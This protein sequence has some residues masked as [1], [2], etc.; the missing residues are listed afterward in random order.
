MGNPT[1][2][3]FNE[4]LTNYSVFVVLQLR[5][6]LR[7]MDPSPPYLKANIRYTTFSS[8]HPPSIPFMGEHRLHG[9]PTFSFGYIRVNIKYVDASGLFW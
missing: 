3:H 1:R 4:G 9:P 5:A 6:N 7:Y 2:T 8:L